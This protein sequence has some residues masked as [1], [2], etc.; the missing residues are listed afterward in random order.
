MPH[1]SEEIL[2]VKRQTG[3]SQAEGGNFSMWINNKKLFYYTIFYLLYIGKTKRTSKKRD[4]FQKRTP[5]MVITL[6]KTY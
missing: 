4:E 2:F 3:I 6:M 1:K 5:Q